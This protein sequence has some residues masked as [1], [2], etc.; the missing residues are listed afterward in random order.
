MDEINNYI[1][2]YIFSDSNE[3]KIGKY[4][5]N[6]VSLINKF[7]RI[8]IAFGIVYLIS[9]KMSHGDMDHTM[10]FNLV[11]LISIFLILIY[12][13]KNWRGYYINNFLGAADPPLG[14]ECAGDLDNIPKKDSAGND[15]PRGIEANADILI[16]AVTVALVNELSDWKNYFGLIGTGIGLRLLHWPMYYAA[17]TFLPFNCLKGVIFFVL[18]ASKYSPI[19]FLFGKTGSVDDPYI[20]GNTVSEGKKGAEETPL[21]NFNEKFYLMYIVLILLIFFTII[22]RLTSDTVMDCK[23]FEGPIPF[24]GDVLEGC[25]GYRFYMVLN[26]LLFI[27][28]STDF[29]DS[30]QKI[31]LEDTVLSCPWKVNTTGK[32]SPM[33]EQI[34]KSKSGECLSPENLV[35]TPICYPEQGQIIECKP[36]IP[37]P[38]PGCK[39]KRGA[40]TCELNNITQFNSVNTAPAD[41]ILISKNTNGNG[42][43]IDPK[44]KIKIEPGECLNS[45]NS[46]LASKNDDKLFKPDPDIG[47]ASGPSSNR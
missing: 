20:Y 19:N 39:I 12:I 24:M 15:C 6:V 38:L 34:Y 9:T 43:V 7:I 8:I 32:P 37:S 5:N 35:D 28:F 2:K 10:Y 1:D 40:N 41:R 45:I 16:D 42:Y 18:F 21:I 4:G 44:N 29:I 47:G 13:Q 3:S 22:I 33:S 36:E 31:S 23:N 25:S 30:L 46:W 17:F 11:L 27:G 26:V 14:G